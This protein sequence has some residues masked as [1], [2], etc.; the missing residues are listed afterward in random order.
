MPQVTERDAYVVSGRRDDPLE[1]KVPEVTAIWRPDR[2][3]TVIVCH[4]CPFNHT[5]TVAEAMRYAINA[6]MDQHKHQHDDWR[7]IAEEAART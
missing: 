5:I 6:T 4:H 2:S 7:Q 3:E 1:I